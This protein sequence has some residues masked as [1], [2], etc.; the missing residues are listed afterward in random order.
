[1]ARLLSVLSS[2]S[3][4]GRRSS[5]ASWRQGGKLSTR[6]VRSETWNQPHTTIHGTALRRQ[7]TIRRPLLCARGSWKQRCR[8]HGG[9]SPG[10]P[11]GNQNAF[12]GGAYT[13][14]SI[15]QKRELRD[16]G[17][18]SD[19]C[20]SCS[21]VRS[22]GS[23]LANRTQSPR[24]PTKP[25]RSTSGTAARRRVVIRTDSPRSASEVIRCRRSLFFYCVGWFRALC[26][27]HLPSSRKLHGSSP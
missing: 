13:S 11:K 24:C 8:M 12:K 10:A 23:E 1:M 4:A 26:G 16:I 7:N 15:R 5:R 14:A 18:H 2:Q 21:G 6:G 25:L 3:V 17:K 9:Q 20:A 27:R 19:S 22:D